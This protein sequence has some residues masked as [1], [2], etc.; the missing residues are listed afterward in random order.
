M[1]VACDPPVTVGEST[2][3]DDIVGCPAV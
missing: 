3:I 2:S 1:P